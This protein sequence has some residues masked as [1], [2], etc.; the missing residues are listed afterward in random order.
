MAKQS[1]QLDPNAASYSDDEIVG[2]VNAATANITRAGSVDAAARPIVA[3]EVGATELAA[4]EY[5]AA[6][7]TKLAAV[8]DSATADQSAAEIRDAIVG[9]A[10]VDRQIVITDPQASE[11]KV[12]SIQ[13]DVAGKLDI[14]YDDVAV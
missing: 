11:F 14:D 9:L 3:G 7:Q 12:I 6:E 10:D 2:K 8:E 1:F 4:E 13:R 5:T